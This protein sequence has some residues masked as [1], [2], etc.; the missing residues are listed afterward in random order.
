M[1]EMT[2]P[3][4]PDPGRDPARRGLPER[5]LLP[6]APREPDLAATYRARDFAER[7][8]LARVGPEA[9]DGLGSQDVEVVAGLARA[10]LATAWRL[11]LAGPVVGWL[12]LMTLWGFGRSTFPTAEGAWLVA[13]LVAGAV[14]GLVVAVA[15]VRRLRRAQAVLD[16]T[17]RGTNPR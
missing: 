7:Q 2:E 6:P 9:L 13:G 3:R 5:W 11:H 4:R 12:A 1:I 8:A 15:V 10:R 14:V 17:E 16:A